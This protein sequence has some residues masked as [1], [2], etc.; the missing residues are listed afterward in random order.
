MKK[1]QSDGSICFERRFVFSA[2]KKPIRQLDLRRETIR[3]LRDGSHGAIHGGITVL[4]II[5]TNA[6]TCRTPQ[7]TEPAIEGAG[8]AVIEGVVTAP[9]R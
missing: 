6:F 7:P 2:M 1:R 9:D 4:T 3:I 8:E 5:F